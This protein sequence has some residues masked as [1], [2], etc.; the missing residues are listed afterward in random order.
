M[1][2]Q[3]TTKKWRVYLCNNSYGTPVVE[4]DRY[5]LAHDEIG[6]GYLLFFTGSEEIALFP[7]KD[8]MGVTPVPKS[9][10]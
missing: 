8:V 3:Q 7:I 4:A 5:E 10:D 2:N 9:N 6:Y 1:A